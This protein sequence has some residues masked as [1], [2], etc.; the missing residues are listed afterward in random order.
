[1][2]RLEEEEEV[3]GIPRESINVMSVCTCSSFL[4]SSIVFPFL[5]VLTQKFDDSQSTRLL[6]LFS[7]I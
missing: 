1:M 2:N 7:E 3:M 5:L 4:S 6:N